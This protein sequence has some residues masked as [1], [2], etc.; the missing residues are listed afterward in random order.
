MILRE[1]LKTMRRKESIT[2]PNWIEADRKP[3]LNPEA[4]SFH[5]H[6]APQ[7]AQMTQETASLTQALINSLN[8]SRL[9][10]PEP[11]TFT[12]DPIKFIDLKITFT[13]LIDHKSIS[14]SEM[15]YLAGEAR[16]AVEGFF[17][18]N[19]EDAYQGAWK[20][21]EERYG[22]SFIVQRAFRERLMKWPK[23]GTND[24]LS[25]RE[26]TGFL[27]GCVEAVPHVKGLDILN[28]CEENY[29]LLKK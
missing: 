27:Q 15:F 9:P 3:Q 21:L 23:I 13:V 22:N 4:E 7:Q 26:F 17:Y 12:V 6:Q 8:I 14:A 2:R 5:P 1:I 11:T 29:K 28:D 18:R 25:L 10:I 19:S 24:P 16:K 20:V